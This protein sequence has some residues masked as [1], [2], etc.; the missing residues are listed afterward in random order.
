V[1]VQVVTGRGNKGDAEARTALENLTVLGVGATP[2]Q[3]SQGLSLPVVTL[4][5]NPMEADILAT[6]DSGASVRLALR[7]PLDNETRGRTAITL[8][9]IMRGT[10]VSQPPASASANSAA[11]AAAAK[12]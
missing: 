10:V 11:N 4:L 12:R 2:E 1:D 3:N 7:N 6:A 9:S 8:N 5:A